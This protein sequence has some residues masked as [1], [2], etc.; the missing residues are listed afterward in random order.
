M[1]G[2]VDVG[3][4]DGQDRL[5]VVDVVAADDR[6]RFGRCHGWVLLRGQAGVRR[7]GRTNVLTSGGRTRRRP[8]DVGG[9][10][11][12]V[13]QHDAGDPL[14]GAAGL[15]EV[16]TEVTGE[17]RA[18]EGVA[19]GP[20]G[21][22]S[23]RKARWGS[24]ASGSWASRY[25]RAAWA[26]RRRRRPRDA[27]DERVLEV[28]RRRRWRGPRPPRGRS[29]SR[30]ATAANRAS[31]PPGNE[32]VDGRPAAAGLAGHVVEGGLGHAPA[33]DAAQ[34]GVDQVGHLPET[35]R[36]EVSH[37]QACLT[38]FTAGPRR[39][40][41]RCRRR[42]G[43]GPGR[44]G[45]TALAADEAEEHAGHVVGGLS[46]STPG[47]IDDRCMAGTRNCFTRAMS[48]PLSVVSIGSSRSGSVS[49]IFWR[50][51]CS[52]TAR[53]ANRSA[54]SSRSASSTWWATARVS[55]WKKRRPP[56]RRPR[57]ELVLAAREVAVDGRAGEAGLAGHVLHRRLG[58]AVAGD[59]RVGG[60]EQ[61]LP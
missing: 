60:L 39:R 24:T 11:A 46:T 44:S 58:Q 48:R 21:R 41:A 33:G 30:S 25:W 31:L 49:R 43:P 47:S 12:R 50:T 8:V 34:G 28:R 45:R 14:G 35:L 20:A 53:W 26:A 23:P 16:A 1:D 61:P 29:S 42:G 51:S 7:P 15:V 57:H 13:G 55:R 4:G 19:P 37:R 27:G 6:R 54:S 22:R 10:A 2:L 40:A 18:G 52:S 3:V 32:A 59:A 56:R 38:A 36:Q 17:Q 9:G 5:E